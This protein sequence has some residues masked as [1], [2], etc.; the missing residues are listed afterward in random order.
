MC[1]ES[2]KTT[3]PVGDAAELN[4]KLFPSCFYREQQEHR[5]QEIKLLF[6]TATHLERFKFKKL[7][8]AS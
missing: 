1:F 7:I 3:V 2:Y 5:R 4:I 8:N 6:V